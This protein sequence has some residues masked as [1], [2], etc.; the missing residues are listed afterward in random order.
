MRPIIFDRPWVVVGASGHANHLPDLPPQ[1]AMVAGERSL[2]QSTIEIAAAITDLDRILVIVSA[3]HAD[4]ARE[5]IGPI[6]GVELVVQPRDLDTA[7]ALLLPLARI[8]E[9]DPLGRVVFLP[10]HHYIADGRPL[11]DALAAAVLPPVRDHVTLIGA[12]PTGTDVEDGWIVRG[13]AFDGMKAYEVGRLCDVPGGP[14]AERMRQLG[15]LWNT[16]IAAGPITTFWDLVRAHLPEHAACFERYIDAIGTRDERRT[17]IDAYAEMTPADFNR[18]LLA[19]AR[20]LA[21]IPTADTGW[22]DWDSP[23]EVIDK[24]QGTPL[25]AHLI[26]RIRE[27]APPPF[28]RAS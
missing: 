3:R 7:P 23:R 10:A 24:L 9:R 12:T 21:V 14:C 13:K 11:L 5:Q 8:L 17:L 20:D 22:S 27:S 6:P 25:F 19:K 18:D 28:V 4:L 1:F 26:A 16:L 2:L 15:G